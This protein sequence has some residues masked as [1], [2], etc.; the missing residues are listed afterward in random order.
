M[1]GHLMVRRSQ[2][3]ILLGQVMRK[4]SISGKS[5]YIESDSIIFNPLQLNNSDLKN[6]DSGVRMH[7]F[8]YVKNNKKNLERQT[9]III[10]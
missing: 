3:E 2:R 4:Q 7:H 8:K 6:I 9:K 10:D 5:C 1:V